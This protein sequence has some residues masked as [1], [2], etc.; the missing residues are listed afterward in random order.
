MNRKPI[1][2]FRCLL[3]ATAL[4]LVSTSALGQEEEDFVWP[5]SLKDDKGEVVIYQPQVESYEGNVVEARAAVSVQMAGQDAP[6]FGAMWFK[7][8]L[9]TDLETRT[10]SLDRVEVT[11]ARFPEIEQEKVDN[12]SR[13]LETEIPKWDYHVSID[14]LIASLPENQGGDTGFS[15]DPPEIFYRSVPAVLVLIDGDPILMDLEGYEL[16]YVV[17]SAFF[18]V[19][20]K[21]T[22]Y[23]LRGGGLWF[24]SDDIGGTWKKTGDLP[25]DIAKVSQKIDED[26]QALAAQK[27]EDEEELELEVDPNEADPEIIISTVSAELIVTSGEPDFTP[28]ENTQLLY[29][30]NTETDVVMDIASQKYFILVSG[31]WFRSSSLSDNKWEFVPFEELPADFANIPED[32]EMASIRPSVPGTVESQ[33]ALL[34]SQIPQTAEIDR[35]TATTEVTY[36]GDPQFES[37]AEGVAYAINTESD[38][39]L[40]DKMY[41]CVDN[42]VWFVSSGPSGPWA[43]ATEVP[44]V[45]QDL[46]PECP[47]YN[48]KYVYIYDSTPEV[49]YVGYTSGYYGSYAWGSCVVYGTGWYYHPWYGYYYYPRAVTYGWGVHY[50]PYAGWGF[51]YGASYGWVT[52]RVGWG[53]PYSCWGRAGYR[54]GYR[55]GYARGYHHGARHGYKR[56]AAHGY[57]AG[58]NAG[59]RNSSN[60]AYR[61]RNDG[62]KHT[63]DVRQDTGKRPSTSDNRKNNVY[64]DKNGDVYRDKDGGWEKREDG[65][66]K[67]DKSREGDREN[68][69]SKDGDRDREG[70]RDQESRDKSSKDQGTRDQGSQDRSRDQQADK[71]RDNNRNDQQQLD[72]DRS[73]R[74][75]GT[76]RQ[77]QS[78]NRSGGGGSRGGGGGRRR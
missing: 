13:Y 39:L 30:N 68:D 67:E 46:P 7:S 40:I 22:G 11:A 34:E 78:P 9:T 47:V 59:Q 35:K 61:N 55:R 63:G 33:E 76:Q 45:I 44:A 58:Y 56:G 73:S 74:D 49:V 41:Y 21:K 51:H 65:Q 25:A 4:L 10:A 36:D 28:I 57:R 26:E 62:V 23:Y 17:N 54:H 19:T 37:C 18:I 72:R 2:L 16:E 53:S 64:A 43:V 24:V 3:M 27:A 69:R 66:W 12:L 15:A 20:D 52:V 60:N 70:T 48:V 38:V 1:S 71:S 8:F 29:L 77:Q 14:R 75:R 42:A 6:I 32:S 31:R 5:K 50:S